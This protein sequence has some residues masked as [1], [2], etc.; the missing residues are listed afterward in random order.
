MVAIGEAKVKR[1]LL[2]ELIDKIKLRLT[3][4]AVQHAAERSRQLASLVSHTVVSNNFVLMEA[5]FDAWKQ[6]LTGKHFREQQACQ[7]R[8]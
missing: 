1:K 2:E 8:R 6:Q 3:F 5:V 7:Y 4:N